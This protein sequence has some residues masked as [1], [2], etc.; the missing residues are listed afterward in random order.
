[1]FLTFIKIPGEHQY[2]E[3]RLPCNNSPKI[4]NMAVLLVSPSHSTDGLTF[5]LIFMSKGLVTCIYKSNK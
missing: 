1:M 4:T 2:I 3:K 5:S